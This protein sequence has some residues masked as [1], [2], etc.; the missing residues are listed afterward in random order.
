MGHCQHTPAIS[1]ENCASASERTP[2]LPFLMTPSERDC[3]HCG[4]PAAIKVES[5]GGEVWV[6]DECS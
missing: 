3:T 6:C 1:C 4:E 5:S 2:P